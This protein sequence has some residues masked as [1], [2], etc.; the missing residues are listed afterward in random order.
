MVK[1]QGKQVPAYHLMH[2]IQLGECAGLYQW[3]APPTSNDGNT[4]KYITEKLTT[5][6]FPQADIKGEWVGMV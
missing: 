2:T 1:P 5:Q 6:G 3:S 4:M